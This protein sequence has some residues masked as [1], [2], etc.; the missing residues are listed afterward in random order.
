VTLKLCNSENDFDFVPDESSNDSMSS[1]SSSSS[2][3]DDENEIITARPS[4]VQ[5][6]AAVKAGEST[7]S[8][9]AGPHP[10][11]SRSGEHDN[12]GKS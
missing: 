9:G 10:E 2:S 3:I 1:S 5:L 11:Q 8:F 4:V 7:V 12:L 6:A